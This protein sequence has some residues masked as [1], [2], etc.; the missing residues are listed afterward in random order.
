MCDPL[1]GAAAI[2]AGSSLLG[3]RSQS[4][5]ARQA[6][7]IAQDMSREQIALY[8]DIFNKQRADYEPFRQFELQ[9]TNAIGELFGFDPV[10]Q[11]AQPQTQTRPFYN[12]HQ[13]REIQN[14]MRNEPGFRNA[15]TQFGSGMQPQ[16]HALSPDR[17]AQITGGQAA[18]GGKMISAPIQDT[19]VTPTQNG[20]QVLGAG[21]MQPESGQVGNIPMAENQTPGLAPTLDPSVAGADR[22]NNSAFN[23]VFTNNFNRD[24]DNIDQNLAN[25]G[26]A[27]S[28]ARLNAIENSR[29][30][31]FQ[32]AFG[33]YINTLMGA[34][35]A[36]AATQGMA[37][38]GAN[39][40]NSAGSS[41]GNRG[42]GMMNSALNA[43]NA[44]AQGI[45][46]VGSAFNFALGSGA[47]G[48]GGKPGK[49]GG[50]F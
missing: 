11:P 39:F 50:F 10:G 34:P 4:S 33:N 8:R 3:S 38:A 22:F 31:N 35:S 23:A 5:A 2:G 48:G 14:A 17:L 41:I 20:L 37:N 45:Q 46:G 15:F 6:G 44:S 26:L 47:F 36:G 28:G 13:R 18:P 27:Y 29:A 1:I 12:A 42:V 43:G 49:P 7:Q 32:N 21:A 16:G 9:R 40:A 25:Q 19:T 30:N 24:R